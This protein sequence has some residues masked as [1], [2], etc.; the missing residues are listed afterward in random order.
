MRKKLTQPLMSK[1]LTFKF[2][3]Y[4][5]KHFCCLKTLCK[6]SHFSKESSNRRRKLRGR[7]ARGKRGGSSAKIVDE[8]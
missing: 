8:T 6:K 5:Q 2:H 1:I 7:V 4:K 3:A